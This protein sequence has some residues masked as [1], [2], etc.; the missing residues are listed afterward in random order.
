MRNRRVRTL[1]ISLAILT[2]ICLIGYIFFVGIPQLRAA[3]DSDNP[4]R[5]SLEEIR[6]YLLEFTPIDMSMED[7]VKFINRHEEWNIVQIDYEYGY[8]IDNWGVPGGSGSED[9]SIGEKSIRVIIGYY[10]DFFQTA[11]SAYYGFDE[12]S[13]LIGIAVRKDTDAP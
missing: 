9:I 5:R 3:R 6:A 11:V 1:L 12:N 7:V 10:R 4:L 2:V 13:K 8:S